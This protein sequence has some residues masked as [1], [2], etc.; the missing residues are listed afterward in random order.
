MFDQEDAHSGTDKAFNHKLSKDV[1]NA[2]R[3]RA[4]GIISSALLPFDSVTNSFLDT[5]PMN[6]L[7]Y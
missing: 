4:F 6:I 1:F 3:T 2:N 7:F 5:P